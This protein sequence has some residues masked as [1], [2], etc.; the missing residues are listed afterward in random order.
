[1]CQIVIICQM[2][3]Y[4]FSLSH[5]TI[6]FIN[7][8]FFY[9]SLSRC[10]KNLQVFCITWFFA[11]CIPRP[12]NE[13]QQAFLRTNFW[14]ILCRFDVDAVTLLWLWSVSSRRWRNVVWSLWRLRTDD[15]RTDIQ[16]CIMNPCL[17]IAR[18]I[19]G[20]LKWNF[21]STWVRC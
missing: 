17:T 8:I 9:C 5:Q 18:V 1:M 21:P 15:N 7:S 13:V 14:W 3:I 16:W 12:S 20:Q 2:Y 10:N 4:I 11:K 6:R 19:M